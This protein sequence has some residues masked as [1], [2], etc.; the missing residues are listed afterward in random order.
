MLLRQASLAAFITVAA[1][2]LAAS[3][4]LA[5]SDGAFVD[6]PGGS[7]MMGSERFYP[8]EGPAEKVTVGPFAISTTE[9]TN[10]QFAAFVA[11]T[12]YVTT[13]EQGLDPEKYPDVPEELRRPG[14]MVFAQPSE[15]VSLADP[16]A[17]WRYVTGADWR[18]PTGPDS[19]IEGLGH[20]PVVQVSPED[21]AAYAA[22]AGGRLP[23]EAEWE[24]AARGGLDAADYAWGQTYQA[25]GEA[26]KANTWQGLFPSV[27]MAED[28]HHGTA[29]AASFAPN[30]YGL[31]DMI[32]N[33]WEYV[34]D[35]WVPGHV[36]G[37]KVDPQGP[38]AVV[39]ARFSSPA[40][41][42]RRVVKGGSWLC[43]PSYCQ[44]YRPSARQPAELSLGTNHIGF[45]IVKDVQS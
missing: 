41:G 15:R 21:A 1:G 18:H 43:A 42:P 44:R 45:R 3:G 23:T 4:A 33:V 31:Y 29:P 19:S 17:W 32:G 20:H 9:V 35:Y 24:F 7:F 34:G 36:P 28:G 39:A 40:T 14:S 26:W 30:G 8:E 38:D 22:W 25:P 6:L 5:Q 27:D 37:P 11:A 12:G 10:D 2:A 13:A 16:N